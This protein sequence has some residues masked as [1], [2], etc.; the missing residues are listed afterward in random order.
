M[1]THILRHKERTILKFPNIFGKK[2]EPT[3]PTRRQQLEKLGVSIQRSDE[4]EVRVSKIKELHDLVKTRL[5][6][7]EVPKGA[8]PLTAEE[9]V[10]E[11]WKKDHKIDVLIRQASV[12][13]GRGGDVGWYR[14][15]MLG[16]ENL[17]GY[18]VLMIKSV[19]KILVAEEK[20]S[21]INKE[22][23]MANLEDFL[24]VEI[25]LYALFITDVSY[26]EKDVS[27]AYLITLQQQVQGGY[28]VPATQPGSL[29]FPK[30]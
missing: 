29:D 15:A 13:W 16:W 9:K 1:P 28:G 11:L 14:E 3:E 5:D 18:G 22:D 20:L 23:L 26:F 30:G 6:D 17:H 10:T 7:I 8:D 27:P 4:L 12:P 2:E 25:W 24:V 19:Q 21:F